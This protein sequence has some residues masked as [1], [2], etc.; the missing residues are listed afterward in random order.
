MAYRIPDT[1]SI[2][3]WNIRSLYQNRLEFIKLLHDRNPACVCLNETFL[4]DPN[5]FSCR[6]YS[7]HFETN[8]LQ[9]N[10]LILVRH[11][12][13]FQPLQLQTTLNALSIQLHLDKRYT[14]CSIYLK[15]SEDLDPVLLNDLLSQLPSP[16]L[17]LG[18]F[19]AR[20]RSWFDVITNSRGNC[21]L[22]VL[23]SHCLIVLNSDS[24]THLDGKTGTLSHIDLS[25]CTADISRDLHWSTADSTHGSDHYPIFIQ[26][27]DTIVTP[28]YWRWLYHKADWESFTCHSEFTSA[29]DESSTVSANLNLLTSHIL[30][31]ASRHIPLLE[32]VS[33][34]PSVPWWTPV[35]TEAR[36]TRNWAHRILR[37][38]KTTANYLAYKKASAQ[39]RRVYKDAQRSSWRRYVSTI[40]E[41][42]PIAKI[43]KTINKFSGKSPRSHAPTLHVDG[44]VIS[45]PQDV[46]N[47]I[48]SALSSVSCGSLDPTFCTHK[49]SIESTPLD[50]STNN[51]DTYN[52][53]LSMGELTSSLDTCSDSAPGEDL[54]SFQIIRHLH[55]SCLTFL[56]AM[57]QH[58]WRSG[59][60]PAAW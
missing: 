26:F 30:Q 5:T 60:F 4:N 13:P 57:F 34:K 12:I 23:Q 9:R 15:P 29:Y 24:P 19:N 2:M 46:S 31:V 41:S 58:I 37:A 59:V 28:S 50:F 52:A 3:Q 45:H 51:G 40:T 32:A 39:T 38:N 54:I 16:F 22:N 8:A 42:T 53:D 55:V 21:I 7:S 14:V 25:V 49:I 18:D 33:H 48:A 11:D 56:L 1:L 20:H 35:C 44:N 6:M 10:N 36:R 47:E 43:W 27:Q 17:L